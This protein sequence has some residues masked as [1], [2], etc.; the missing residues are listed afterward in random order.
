MDPIRFGLALRA[1]RQHRGWRQG[2]AAASVGVSDS[3][4]SRIERGLIEAVPYGTLE[5][6]GRALGARVE[7][8]ARWQGEAIDRLLDDPHARLE[9]ATADL[10]RVAHW[11]V[12][13]EATFSVY[14]ERGSIDVFAFHPPTRLVAVNEC[15]S[16]VPDAGNTLLGVDRKARLALQ[17]ARERGWN[18]DGV[19]KFLVLAEGRTNRRRIAQHQSLFE[20][21]F[22]VIGRDAAAWIRSPQR[23]PISG[24]VYLPVDGGNAGRRHR[25]DP[26]RRIPVR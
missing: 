17:I 26:P 15:K 12:V 11:E 23:P 13:V 4:I 10:Y 24:L 21:A 2:D 14:G 19:A 8:L 25:V 18:A 5:A 6:V 9:A 20:A 7:L 22:P 1:L 16:V 3:T